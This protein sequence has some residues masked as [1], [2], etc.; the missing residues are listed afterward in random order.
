M[1]IK[2]IIEAAMGF[3][4]FLGMVFLLPGTLTINAIG[5]SVDEDGGILRSLINM[6]FWGVIAVVIVFW[7]LFA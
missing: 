7:Y 1:Y 3:L 5:I 6:L 2:Y 4:K